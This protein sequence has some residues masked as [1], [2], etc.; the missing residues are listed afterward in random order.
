[1]KKEPKISSIQVKGLII[2]SIIGVGVLS[3]PNTLANI[4]EKDGWIPIIITGPL[5]ILFLTIII[6]MFRK[7]PGKDYFEIG[8]ENLGDSLFTI[9]LLIFFVYLLIAAAFVVRNLGELIK[10][11]LLPR[12]PMEVIIG[13]FILVTSYIATYEIDVIARTGYF[14]YPITII[15]SILLILMALPRADFG[16]ILPTFQADF[17]NIPKGI[18][19]TF[20]S[21]TGFEIILFAIPHVEDEENVLKSSISGIATVTIIY[22]ALFI[23]TLTQFNIEQIQRQTFPVL[24]MAKLLDLPGYFLQNLDNI[25]LGIW[26]LVVFATLA[27]IYYGAGKIVSEIFKTKKH[28]YYILILAPIIYFLALWPKNIV[29]VYRRLGTIFN[30][31]GIISVLLLPLLLCIVSSIKGREAKK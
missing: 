9:F 22:S 30:I 7:N 4:L 24:M 10:A 3:L 6:H 15:F 1:M 19:M 26:V 29:E 12:T 14:I 28:K 23:M 5:I 2:S 18:L 20:F 21:Y 8:R 27:P 11:F 13:S 16:N 31:L 25:F 17:R